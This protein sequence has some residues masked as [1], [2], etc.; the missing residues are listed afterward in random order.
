M[1]EIESLTERFRSI[2]AVEEVS[3]RIAPGEILG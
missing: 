3:F 1:L 2:P